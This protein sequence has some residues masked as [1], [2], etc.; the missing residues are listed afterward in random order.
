MFFFL[1]LKNVTGFLHV[2]GRMGPLKLEMRFHPTNAHDGKRS[3]S[4]Q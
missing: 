2:L 3:L 1:N 4:E